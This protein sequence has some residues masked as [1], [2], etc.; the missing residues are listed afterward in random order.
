MSPEEMLRHAN[1]MAGQQGMYGLTEDSAP[2]EFS[3]APITA[4][5]P[6][7]GTGTDPAYVPGTATS[8]PV[9][10]ETLMSV[11]IASYPDQYAA[12]VQSAPP[13]AAPVAVP[14]AAAVPQY[15]EQPRGYGGGATER[16]L[17]G[18]AQ[19]YGGLAESEQEKLRAMGV[20][21]PVSRA[22]LLDTY[23]SQKEAAD[24]YK[25]TI[26][27]AY[28]Q[29]REWEAAELA[30]NARRMQDTDA[31][32]QLW[33][34]DYKS[35]Q[36]AYDAMESP[37]DR[38]STAT[39][40]MGA[41][42]VGLSGLGDSFASLGGQQTDHADKTLAIINA[43][44]ERDIQAQREK[45]DALERQADKSRRRVEYA[46]ERSIEADALER[47]SR[48]RAYQ[49]QLNVIAE[50][51]KG[52]Q[53]GLAAEQAAAQ[54]QNQW[55]ERDEQLAA[56][57][58]DE[59]MQR[60]EQAQRIIAERKDARAGAAAAAAARANDPRERLAAI[61]D[62]ASTRKAI[63]EADKAEA[64]AA[65]LAGGKKPLSE[66]QQAQVNALDLFGDTANKILALR[67]QRTAYEKAKDA[68][69]LSA[70]EE[71]LDAL[72]A[73]IKLQYNDAMGLGA[74]DESSME[75]IDNAL[76]G[77]SDFGT[78]TDVKLK[79]V[80]KLISKQRSYIT[81]SHE[82]ERKREGLIRTRGR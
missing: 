4:P 18:V 56:V 65:Q 75:I 32:V 77:A 47:G 38:R 50:Q 52:T 40:A 17:G 41:L 29:S 28:Q 34:E 27:E 30:R 6:E 5:L 33:R 8:V 72:G 22:V 54:L 19:R 12:P 68:V 48:E 23:A 55:A 66:K 31:Q 21:V 36:A 26:G 51:Y 20:D 7:Y 43:A 76:G 74:L 42:A 35:R 15:A 16:F 9:N 70:I 1:R 58:R 64:E 25:K 80:Q 11:P 49:R 3:G 24:A 10:P 59:Y 46:E 60:M 71:Q 63:A 81:G 2:D 57:K 82:E 39:I 14:Q 53:V 61:R 13:L 78:E 79:A 69:G 73:S 67:A 37:H 45:K 62:E 44:V